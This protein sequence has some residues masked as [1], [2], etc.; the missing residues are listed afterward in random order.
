MRIIRHYKRPLKYRQQVED[1]DSF[2]AT[3]GT[4]VWRVDDEGW[5]ETDD[6]GYRRLASIDGWFL[7]P[8]QAGVDYEMLGF[9]IFHDAPVYRLRR[10]FA[11]GEQEERL[12][13]VD[14]GYLTEIYSEY[15]TGT[16]VMR[17]YASL[18]GYRET[19]GIQ[20]PHV[21]I[22]NV[23]P[24]GPPHGVVIEEVSINLPLADSLFAPTK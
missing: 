21:F 7:D 4:H 8:E 2:M 23:G 9:E 13:S 18:W 12:F 1:S 17:A 11:D 6:P 14:H 15:P 10:A 5:H 24:L 19:G 20:L 22:R 3:D 16:P